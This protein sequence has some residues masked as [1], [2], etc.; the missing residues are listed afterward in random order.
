MKRVVEADLV[1]HADL[2]DD[3]Q[4]KATLNWFTDAA[5]LLAQE[6]VAHMTSA[7][8]DSVAA[9]QV[10]LI[11]CSLMR[12]AGIEPQPIRDDLW[13]QCW[14]ANMNYLTALS[15]RATDAKDMQA[16]HRAYHQPI[17]LTC[18]VTQSRPLRHTAHGMWLYL[19]MKTLFD[20][21]ELSD[22]L[23]V[24]RPGTVF[25]PADLI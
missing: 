23:G 5:P 18:L 21:M 20:A 15:F 10:I 6:I 8:R 11:L 12:A 25:V 7:D 9:M 1:R 17:L 13:R 14:D 16:F 3:R 19:V 24:R 4:R 22:S 2:G